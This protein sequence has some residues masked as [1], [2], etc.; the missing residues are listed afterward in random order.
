MVLAHQM[1]MESELVQA[2]CVEAMEFPEMA[3]H[4]GVSGVPHTAINV[5]A[6]VMV[7]AAPEVYLVEQIKKALAKD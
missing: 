7:G 3:S 6:G 1:A 4:Y 5:D 2:D